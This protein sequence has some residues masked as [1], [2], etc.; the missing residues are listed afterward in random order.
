MSTF[1]TIL[2]FGGGALLGAGAVYLAIM[3]AF[4][5]AWR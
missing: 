1:T 3:I 5:R 4:A 2:I